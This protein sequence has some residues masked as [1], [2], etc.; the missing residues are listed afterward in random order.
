MQHDGVRK[1][2]KA[3]T[4][5]IKNQ[6]KQIEPESSP[7]LFQGP[8]RPMAPGIGPETV[9]DADWTCGFGILQLII[10]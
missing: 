7:S 6:T 9:T 2:K 10:F 8:Q 3:K 1:K 4:N 5:R